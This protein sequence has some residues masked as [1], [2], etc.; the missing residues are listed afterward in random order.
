MTEYK[1]P[2][3]V[4]TTRYQ[5][6]E[7]ILD[8]MSTV[9][10]YFVDEKPEDPLVLVVEALMSTLP[11]DERAVVEMCLMAN[12]SMHEAARMLGYI[13]ASG[14]EDHKKV[15]RRL[16]WALAKLRETLNSPTFSLA[17]AGHKLPVTQPGVNI[18]E[19]LSK[20]IDGFEKHIQEER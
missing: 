5:H 1:R 16:E 12:I 8:A 3:Q 10:E 13:N 20:I 2:L 18:T 14:R 11:D 7:E 19:T 17:I 6:S 15:K 9:D 4:D